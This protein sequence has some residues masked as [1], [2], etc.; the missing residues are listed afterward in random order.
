[1]EKRHGSHKEVYSISPIY[2]ALEQRILQL[3]M[4]MTWE[5]VSRWIFMRNFT[6]YLS[7]DHDEYPSIE[8]LLKLHFQMK[9]CE[10]KLPRFAC[11]KE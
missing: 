2:T 3:L 5:K 6:C 10:E 8:I 9:I 4:K 11:F 7:D 1:M